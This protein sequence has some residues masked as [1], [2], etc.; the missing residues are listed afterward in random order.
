MPRM[1]MGYG[2][3]PLFD[4]KGRHV[5]TTPAILPPTDVKT[6]RVRDDAE[7]GVGDM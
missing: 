2:Y 3:C 6:G 5:Q 4:A 1:N 7:A